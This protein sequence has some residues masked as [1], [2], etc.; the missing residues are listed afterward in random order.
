MLTYL[1]SKH[2]AIKFE[3]ELPDSDPFLP[4]LDVKI[5]ITE[6]GAIQYKLF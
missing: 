1:N 2:S 3:M 6:T 5:Q 4:I